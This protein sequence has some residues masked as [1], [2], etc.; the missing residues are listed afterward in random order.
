M[1]DCDDGDYCNGVETCSAGAC[2]PGTPP[3][4]DDDIACTI[5]SCN[6]DDDVCVNT[7]DD[8]YCDDGDWCN[9]PEVCTPGVGCEPGTPPD[10]D[11]GDPC[12]IDTCDEDADECVNTPI[13]CNDGNPCTTDVC[14]DG[15]CVYTAIPG[16]GGG[17]GPIGFGP[18]KCYL[19]IDMLGERTWVE[20]DCCEN[21]TLEECEAYDEQE[22]HLLELEYDNLVK[23]SEC[24]G[25]HC[26]PKIIVMSLSDETPELPEG[27][28]AVGPIYDFTGYQDWEREIPCYLVTYFDPVAQVLLSYDPALLPEG[29]T[30]PVIAFYDHTNNQWVILP[31]I[32]G[33]V[34][35][36]GV[37]TG[38]AE[39]FASPFA[40]LVDVPPPAIP[41]PPAP[42][43]AHFVV[44]GLNIT[45]AEVMVEESVTIS[46]NVT[47]DGEETGTYTVEL[48]INGQTI[49]SQVVTLD[50]G[51]S[52]TVRFTVTEA[53]AGQYEVTVSGLSGS[54]TVVKTSLWWIWLIIA[55]VVI[56]GGLLAWRFRKR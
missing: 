3:D 19:V 46:L 12:T 27:M 36:V 7:P 13:V 30:N 23:C 47:N 18:D 17:G 34:A 24:D 1:Y 5:D 21:T 31:P 39:Y 49:D 48:K 29:A 40:V 38:E 15:E 50:G 33:V 53:E 16:C 32:P 42:D 4:C 54:F 22:L 20:I 41:E 37:A 9:G 14:V 26:Y 8:S 45:P 55:A 6:E 52:E 2:V 35:E 28:V 56:I 11:D 10:C 51:Q 25:C 43:P 44:T